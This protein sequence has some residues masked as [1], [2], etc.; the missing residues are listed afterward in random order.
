MNTFDFEG[1]GKGKGLGTCCSAA[2]MSRLKT[3]STLQSQKCQLI[4]VS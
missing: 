4:G 3:G 1:K 2:H